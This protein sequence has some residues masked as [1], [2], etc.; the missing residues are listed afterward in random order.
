MTR[1]KDP[2]GT[3][4]ECRS[5]KALII[6][7]KTE[8]GKNL[9]VDVDT[10]KDGEWFIVINKAEYRVDAIFHKSQRARAWVDGGAPRHKAHWATCP[11][12]NQHRRA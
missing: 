1:R 7:A 12:A 9:P 10:S 2:P 8:K 11:N 4:S 5:C 6:W 3:A